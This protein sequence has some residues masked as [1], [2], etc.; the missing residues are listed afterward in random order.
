MKNQIIILCLSIV[1]TV[2]LT[3]CNYSNETKLGSKDIA[4][5]VLD[6]KNEDTPKAESE[7][8]YGIGSRFAAISKTDLV[9]ATTIYPFNNDE[10]N[11]RIDKVNTTEIIIIKHNR[12]SDRR[13]YGN[14]QDLT[15]AQ[16]ELFKSLDYDKH[17]SMKTLFQEKSTDGE[18]LDERKYNPHY[19]VVPE[20]QAT[21][22]KGEEALINYLI[23]NTKDVTANLDNKKISANKVYFTITKEGLVEN[24]SMHFSTNYPKL[25]N[26]LKAL[27]SNLPAQWNPAKNAKGEKVEQEI[28]FTFGPKGGC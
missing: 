5:L 14:S 13:E 21:Y 6:N 9:N 8:Y 4:L 18:V 17:F 19:T 16:K 2:S 15:K 23:E 1:A 25:D 7:Y 27:I 12:R 24:V 20:T 26:K 22:I 28:V 10:E 11:E 3:S